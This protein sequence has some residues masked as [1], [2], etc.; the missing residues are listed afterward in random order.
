MSTYSIVFKK[1]AEKELAA[2]NSRDRA[3][4]AVA[5]D[6]LAITPRPHGC[7]KLS[8]AESLWRIRVGDFRV[9]YQIEDRIVTVTVVRIGNRR[10]VYRR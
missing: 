2:V 8:G 3:R 6:Q 10:D 4:I 7:E 9:I 1:A 5:I